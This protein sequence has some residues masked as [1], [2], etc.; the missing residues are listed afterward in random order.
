VVE[1][2]ELDIDFDTIPTLAEQHA[3]RLG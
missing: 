1:R 2:Y 3:L